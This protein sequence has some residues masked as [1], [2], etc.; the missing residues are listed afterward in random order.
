MGGVVSGSCLSKY[1]VDF[2]TNLDELFPD[3]S[4]VGGRQTDV[5]GLLDLRRMGK[6]E[7]V[8]ALSLAVWLTRSH[9]PMTK[10][11]AVL[12]SQILQRLIDAEMAGIDVSLSVNSSEIK[13]RETRKVVAE[14]LFQRG[15]I[16]ERVLKLPDV[17]REFYEEAILIDRAPRAHMA[18][19][20]L[21][22]EGK[23]WNAKGMSALHHLQTAIALGE[24]CTHYNSRCR[25][26]V[27]YVAGMEGIL[28][29]FLEPE[30]PRLRDLAV[31]G[32][33]GYDLP[34]IAGLDHA[35]ARDI[36]DRL[37]RHF[38]ELD[39]RRPVVERFSF[40]ASAI[41]SLIGI[42]HDRSCDVRAC[43]RLYA[44]DM[45][46]AEHERPLL[47][48]GESEFSS[49]DCCVAFGKSNEAKRLFAALAALVEDVVD[50][51]ARGSGEEALLGLQ[52]A[53]K[54]CFYRAGRS[55]RGSLIDVASASFL[56][57]NFNGHL[58]LVIP[59]GIG[60]AKLLGAS[61]R[62]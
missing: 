12:I 19:G 46:F 16:F 23:L 37:D 51:I 42:Q 50:V 59:A 28:P 44:D 2:E 53:V 20:V 47:V 55:W 10:A 35:I 36:N 29:E 21:H 34:S 5:R 57:G 24:R 52:Q 38:L 11:R 1:P 3:Y 54:H 60:E 43:L 45:V 14:A 18:L 39:I 31:S 13:D 8:A 6:A 62:L 33:L 48:N 17:A 40:L 7:P 26:A 56:G 61:L 27:L 25:C 15:K 58:R 41:A 22:F 30:M 9:R 4:K 49:F 32:R